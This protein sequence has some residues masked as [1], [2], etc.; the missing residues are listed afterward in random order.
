MRRQVMALVLAGVMA[1]GICGG[2]SAAGRGMR[3]EPR[4]CSVSAYCACARCCGR[5][6]THRRTASGQVPRPGITVAADPTVWPMGSCVRI[7]GVGERIVQDRG[8]AIRGARL[9]V[10][11]GTHTEALRFGR[12]LLV[13]HPC[14]RVA[15]DSQ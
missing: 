2:V 13:V 1:V 12:K 10:F 4:V 6:A 5:W 3:H 7:E 11:F 9:D 8:S 14:G 15:R